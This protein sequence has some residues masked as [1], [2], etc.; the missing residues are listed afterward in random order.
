[1]TAGCATWCKSGSMRIP[2]ASGAFNII[3][4]TIPAS[5]AKC[6][7]ACKSATCPDSSTSASGVSMG[8]PGACHANTQGEQLR[9]SCGAVA[10][11]VPRRCLHGHQQRN[12][13][14]ISLLANRLGAFLGLLF[15]ESHREIPAA[16]MLVLSF[17]INTG[18][19]HPAPLIFINDDIM[20]DAS[21]RENPMKTRRSLAR[22]YAAVGTAPVVVWAALV[23]PGRVAG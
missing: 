4:T 17:P 9:S 3:H 12:D 19:L 7:S 2:Y 16:A 8:L 10:A 1:M 15:G 6:L 11:G 13:N 5:A 21:N 22:L 18:T 14:R 20:A 23:F